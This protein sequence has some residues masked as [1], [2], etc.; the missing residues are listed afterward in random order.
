MGKSKRPAEFGVTGSLFG[1]IEEPRSVETCPDPG[2]DPEA[3]HTT[4]VY[5]RSHDRFLPAV[6]DWPNSA[7][8]TAMIVSAAILFGS[9]SLT[10]EFD[11]RIP[12]FLM[13]GLFGF[14]VL[15]CLL[16]NFRM[17]VRVAT[18]VWVAAVAAALICDAAGSHTDGPLLAGLLVVIACALAA[19]AGYFSASSALDGAPLDTE[20][21]RGRPRWAI[22]FVSAVFAVSGTGALMYLALLVVP[23]PYS[24]DDSRLGG[25]VFY[26]TVGALIIG[27]V[28]AIGA[29]I[30]DG[31]RRMSSHVPYIEDWNGFEP[32]NWPPRRRPVD[33]S[34]V[35]GMNAK[36]D[37]IVRRTVTRI[38]NVFNL[39]VFAV[40][41]KAVNTL[42]AVIRLLVNFLIYVVNVVV[43][44]VVLTSKAVVAAAVCTV[45]I[46]CGSVRAAF[47]SIVNALMVAG[48]PIVAIGLAAGLLPLLAEEVRRYLVDG[49]LG[50]LAA[51]IAVSFVGVISL[52]AAWIMLAN[53]RFRVSLE[54]AG[55]SAGTTGMY[56]SVLLP[57]GGWIVG[58]PGTLGYGQIHVGWVTLVSTT[59]LIAS[60]VWFR[61]QRQGGNTPNSGGFERDGQTD[62]L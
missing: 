20:E 32:V 14:G 37:A 9:F 39:V 57:T 4:D 61:L 11:S 29:G 27:L 58:L 34:P 18:A 40:A 15:A 13:L 52:T 54:S 26:V 33:R 48:V 43:N 59:F 56:G 3:T 31:P 6:G 28:F 19:H 51:F 23:M 16:R 1:F 41:E 46:V 60:L 30:V 17:T 55:R 35:V 22:A 50:S 2:C 47:R 45:W 24:I 8:T 49:S 25:A 38:G 42:F 53:Q 7:R 62:S 12:M 21:R 44:L 10:A 36:I 5:C